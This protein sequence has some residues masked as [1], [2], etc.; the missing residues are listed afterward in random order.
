M[1]NL[2]DRKVFNYNTIW[3]MKEEL[4]NCCSAKIYEETDICTKCNE[5]CLTILI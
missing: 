1:C 5:H 3:N 4:S 2:Y